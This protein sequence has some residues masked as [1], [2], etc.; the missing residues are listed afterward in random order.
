MAETIPAGRS[1]FAALVRRLFTPTE[2][3]EVI[4]R[5]V[6]PPE[7]AP[8]TIA[9][10]S[11]SMAPAELEHIVLRPAA[12]GLPALPP[13]TLGRSGR[14]SAPLLTVASEAKTLKE[15]LVNGLAAVHVD[16]YA[17]VLLVGSAA[18]SLKSA[19]TLDLQANAALLRRA[20]GD[21]QLRV[22]ALPQA[23][24]QARAV[25]YLGGRAD[26]SLVEQVRG[27]AWRLRSLPP[28]GMWWR[29]LLGVIRVPRVIES[30]SP[31]FVADALRQGYI[32][33]LVDQAPVA[34]LAPATLQLLFD[35]PQHLNLWRFMQSL[36]RWP[37]VAAAFLSLLLSAGYVAVTAYHHALIP[38]PFLM[39]LASGRQNMPFPIVMEVLLVELLDDGLLAGAKRLGG[40][41]YAFLA[42]LGTTLVAITAVQSG[43]WAPSS[44]VVV[45]ASAALRL[46]LVNPALGRSVR[47]WRYA[48]IGA[49]AGLGVYGLSLLS[50]AMMAY[51]AQERFFGHLIWKRPAE[52]SSS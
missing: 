32:A 47:I 50:F 24:T 11:G 25:A 12:S 19:F 38:G 16:G 14:F 35:N 23:G 36:L 15:G 4:L 52:V 29:E 42:F 46:V 51:L 34:L 21:P 7:G 17:G 43:V 10:L 20:V 49:A 39:V 33:V 6:D 30:P 28:R 2:L 5:E 1:E 31:A 41:R 9:F 48:F 27:W 13:E 45:L 22:E 3:P 37:R 8:V 40:Q 26:P 18:P 44:A